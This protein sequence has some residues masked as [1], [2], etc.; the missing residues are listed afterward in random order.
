MAPSAAFD[1]VTGT[2]C[3]YRSLKGEARQFLFRIYLD[4]SADAAKDT[5]VRLSAYFGPSKKVPGNWD[6]A[7][8]DAT[9]SLHVQKGKVRYY[10]NINPLMEDPPKVDKEL[11]DLATLVAGEL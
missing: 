1:R 9:H 3:T 8:M 7:Y 4:P 11:T 2:D 10:L 5:F 6:I